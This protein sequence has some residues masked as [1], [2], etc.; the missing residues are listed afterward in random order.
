MCSVWLSEQT[1]TYVLYIINSWV[2]ITEVESVYCAVRADPYIAQISLFLKGL[3]QRKNCD[4]PIGNGSS[5]APEPTAPRRTPHLLLI[6]VFISV[7]YNTVLEV[8]YFKI[9]S[10]FRR[11]VYIA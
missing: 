2:F 7:H 9:A 1:V 8:V 10:K 3:S 5:A 11:P 6:L 4:V